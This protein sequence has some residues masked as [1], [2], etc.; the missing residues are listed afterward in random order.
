MPGMNAT[1]V[2][3]LLLLTALTTWPDLAAGQVASPRARG[4]A[5]AAAEPIQYTVSFPAPHTHYAEI[6]AVVPTSRRPTIELMMAV[7]TPGSYLVREYERNVEGV[8]AS[9]SGRALA[10]EK[11][12]KNRWRITTSGAPSVEV[13]YRVYGREMSV[14]T[15]WIEA[16]FAFLN[17]APTFLTLADGLAR[18]HD[19]SIVP[20]QGWS[21]SFTA[22]P[23][24]GGAHRYRAADFDTLVDSPILVG[25]A[26]AYEF[27]VDGKRHL[28]V[29]EG[30][31]GVFDGAM[32][33]RDLEA[34]VRECRR[35]WGSLPYDQY[36]FFNLLTERSGGLEHKDSSVLMASRWAT[37]SRGAYLS[38]L[39]LASH[40][41]LH[42]WNV[43]RLRP[44][45][46]GP[47]DYE[48]EVTTRSLWIAEGITDYF[49][50]LV[51]VRAGLSSREQ[52]LASLSSRIDE[53]Q[54]SPGRLVQSVEQASF[55][56]WIK[57]YRPDENSNN[58]SISYYTKGAL[59]G[60]LL[61][62]RVR[63]ATGGKRTLEDVMLAAYQKYSGE[64]GY[65]PEEFKAVAEQVA[66]V[67]LDTFW[68]SAVTG[69]ADLDYAEALQVFGLRFGPAPAPAS[70]WLGITTRNENGRLL[71]SQIRRQSP[72]EAAG[73][74]VD[75]EII[76]VDDF[77]IVPDRLDA[78]LNQYRAGDR[79]RVI[80][81][82]RD[83]LL[84]LDVTLGTEPARYGR[85][86]IDP[87][88]PEAAVQQ[89][90]RWLQPG[91]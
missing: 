22:M 87:M 21:K 61:D 25:N 72:A 19:V 40:E 62:A 1:V 32:A 16:G 14:R 48:Q 52:L 29:N 55:D 84:R 85:L 2:S 42:A 83:Q 47:F 54:T 18:P 44:V 70:P 73:I 53:I 13:R 82:R 43:K 35:M 31:S 10:I 65:T 60:F 76:A 15:N 39:E 20:A 90:A 38:W 34:I 58:T 5:A 17:G 79:V 24:A 51:V 11:S 45:E 9:A 80:V 59:V 12:D 68:A 28:L 8:V 91:G 66:G 64:R 27:T 7:W 26:A 6:T 57:Y 23:A 30:E 50:D 75:D 69:T 78:R 49:A 86:T 56:A 89:R 67:S 37:R 88:A 3:L 46:L 71:V 41:L 77:R 74:N 63:R 33:A 81:S 36:V 4:A